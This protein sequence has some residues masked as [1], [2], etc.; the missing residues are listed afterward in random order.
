MFEIYVVLSTFLATVLLNYILNKKKFLTDKKFSDHK[1]FATN[2]IIPITGGLVFLIISL[3]FLFFES[4]V[5]KFFIFFI[6]L[7]GFL[8]DTNYLF[9]PTKRFFLQIFIVSLFVYFSDTFIDS[10]RMTFFDQL[11]ENN[12][13]KYFLTIFCYLVLINGANFMDGI[14]TL[15]LGYF[16][17]IVVIS[18]FVAKKIGITSDINNFLII[19][20]LLSILF[21]FNF[22]G[23]ILSGDSGAYSISFLLGY[24]LIHIS[25]FAEAV[26]PYFVACLLWYPAYECLFSII[27]KKINKIKITQPDNKHLHHFILI[28]FKNKFKLRGVILNTVSGM[29]IN[30]VNYIIFYNAYQNMSQTKNLLFILLISLILYN[31]IF[32]YLKKSIKS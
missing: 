25:N 19:I 28:F 14:N 30:T 6:F 9:S 15:F 12:Y 18:Y 26:S 24:Y 8:S 5:F 23:K 22:F 3:V 20:I 10:L 29:S 17:G 7:I 27:R 16:L 21:I 13:F 11:L 2:E 1:S 32:Y 31:S 4:H